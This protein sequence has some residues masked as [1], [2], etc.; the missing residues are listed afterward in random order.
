MLISIWIRDKF[1]G[2][3]LDILGYWK[4]GFL[5][6]KTPTFGAYYS[7]TSLLLV[8]MEKEFLILVLVV[9][10]HFGKTMR[11]STSHINTK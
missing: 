5:L 3:C 1:F 6:R 9:L 4:L 7:Q 11:A 10:G 2:G 8:T